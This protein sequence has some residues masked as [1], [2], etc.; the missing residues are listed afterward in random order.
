MIYWNNLYRG[1]SLFHFHYSKFHPSLGIHLFWMIRNLDSWYGLYVKLERLH[2]H[3]DVCLSN[4]G[5]LQI[6]IKQRSVSFRVILRLIFSLATEII[7]LITFV[8]LRIFQRN[9]Q[10]EGVKITNGWEENQV[11]TLNFFSLIRTN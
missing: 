3:N 8:F 4:I 10:T 1:V 2:F 6:L 5:R 7:A 9:L 11:W